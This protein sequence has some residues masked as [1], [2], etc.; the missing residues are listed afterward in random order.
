MLLMAAA[1]F[2]APADA[3]DGPP[4]PAHSE[5]GCV[6][7]NVAWRTGALDAFVEAVDQRKPLV[8]LFR[9][10]DEH[11]ADQLGRTMSADLRAD[12][13]VEFGD[14]AV[15][16][17]VVFHH[18]NDLRDDYG[19][20]I[21]RHLRI[22]ES[23]TLL[24]LAPNQEQIQE[25]GRREGVFA[26]AEIKGFVRAFLPRALDVKNSWQPQNS[27]AL[28][29]LL[30]EALRTGDRRMHA[31]CFV[32]PI[33]SRMLEVSQAQTALGN[34]KRR[35]LAAI[36]ER[37]GLQTERLKFVDDDEEMSREMRE[38]TDV[39]HGIAVE[40]DEGA[41]ELPILI[42]R[43][44]ASGA[45]TKQTDKL[46]VVLDR[47]GLRFTA[48]TVKES[49]AALVE[50]VRILNGSAAD[51]DALTNLV[52]AGRFDDGGSALDQAIALYHQRNQSR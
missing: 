48:G 3:Q 18:Q 36:D 21:A 19:E 35:L 31:A 52:E 49:E 26:T 40:I 7:P 39:E 43:V 45:V 25:V 9:N 6:I 34:S 23:P 32:E 29:E 13:L 41:A 14:R 27:Q 50:H 2:A 42:T 30:E 8:I 17:E 38:V 12:G 37:F 10:S 11:D 44:K 4:P 1:S 28:V 46:L 5:K 15:F 33:R 22:T 20:R 51:F 47:N 16:V 24:I